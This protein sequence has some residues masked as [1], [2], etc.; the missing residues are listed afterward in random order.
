MEEN[1]NKENIEE[2][3]TE[4]MEFSLTDLEINELITK[5]CLLKTNREAFNFEVDGEN[6]FLISYE[7]D[8]E[9]E[10]DKE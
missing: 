9:E 8:S 7:E 4:I 6:S 5:L 10:E 1:Y 3:E 2:V